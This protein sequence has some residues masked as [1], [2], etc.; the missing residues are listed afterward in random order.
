M[1]EVL[2]FGEPVVTGR[3][4]QR[5]WKLGN[6]EIDERQ[7][8]LTGH[9]GWQRSDRRTRDKY[10]DQEKRWSDA[11]DVDQRAARSLFAFDGAT[12]YLAVVRH[13]SFNER[14]LT[15]IFEA[16]LQRGEERREVST[17][18]WDVEPILDEQDFREW[19]RRVDRTLALRL[20]LSSTCSAWGGVVN[21][22]RAA[23]RRGAQVRPAV[24]SRAHR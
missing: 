15:R 2:P 4:Y 13:P 5:E 6:R 17:T 3:A 22:G 16:L 10:D 1:A 12:R 11:I 18:D 7:R 14:V 23:A 19:L 9:I 21:A 20:A 24:R 8:I